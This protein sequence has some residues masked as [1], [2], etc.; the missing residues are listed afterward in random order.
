MGGFHTYYQ[1]ETSDGQVLIN[2]T[3]ISNPGIHKVSHLDITI[4]DFD[5]IQVIWLDSVDYSVT[6]TASNR[7]MQSQ[8][9]LI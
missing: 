4:D 8:I 2:A 1:M 5:V 3:Q 7:W 6:Y 9:V